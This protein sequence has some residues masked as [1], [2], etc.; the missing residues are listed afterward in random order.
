MPTFTVTVGGQ[1]YDVEAP[2]EEYAGKAVAQMLKSSQPAAQTIVETGGMLT[3]PLEGGGRPAPEMQGPPAPPSEAAQ[4]TGGALRGGATI[5]AGALAG[6]AI[7]APFGGVGAIPGAAAGAAAAALTEPILEG[8]NRTFGTNYS[9]PD[10]AMQHFLTYLGVPKAEMSSAKLAQAMTGAVAETAAGIGVGK[11]LQAVA[12]PFSTPA[13]VGEALASQP[14][15]QMM[16]AAGAAAG[17]QAAEMAG[18]GVPGQLLAG[19]GGGMLGSFAGAERSIAGATTPKGLREAEQLGI[20]PLTSQAFPPKTPLENALAKAREMTPYGTGSLLQKQ[21]AK[22][23]TE[24]K[25]LLQDFGADIPGTDYLSELTKQLTDRRMGVVNKFKSM[26]MDVINKLSGIGKQPNV[27]HTVQVVS[28]EIKRLRQISGTGYDKAIAELESFGLDV[29]GKNL[30][31][32]EARRKLL[33]LQF[34]APELATVKDEGQKSI[35]AIYGALREDMGNFIKSEGSRTDYIRW[36]IGNRNLSD[37]ADELRDN[38]LKKVLNNADTTPEKVRELLFSQN[39]SSIQ[40]L[41]DNLDSNGRATARAAIL[42]KAADQ[43]GGIEDLTPNRFLGKLKK[44]EDETG[45][46]FKKEEKR[47]LDGLMRALDFTKRAGEFAANPPTGTQLSAFGMGSFLTSIL[48]GVG[49]LVAATGLGTAATRIY[50]SKP[51]RELLLKL[52]SVKAGSPEEFSL[53]KRLG[54]VLKAQAAKVPNQ[55][56]QESK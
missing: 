5:G 53:M 34:N 46:F 40:R 22:R 33:G 42:R 52:P 4:I 18:M 23:I 32:L 39:K 24:A 41:Y 2:N 31:N 6:M 3:A 13:L 36:R 28:D 54:D 44:L 49:G 43:A 25:D 7:G 27:D 19:L 20:E 55:P 51:V 17:T 11:A 16:G 29:I 26:K 15:Q 14:G 30:N 37:M 48:G 12:K 56:Q 21:E 1:E 50:E 8:I 35:E 45:I 47:Q 38:T 10:E 9:K